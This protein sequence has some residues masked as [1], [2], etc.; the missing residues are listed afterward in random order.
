LNLDQEG[1]SASRNQMNGDP[2]PMI[3]RDDVTAET[4]CPLPATDEALSGLKEAFR[5]HAPHLELES[6]DTETGEPFVVVT[7]P[8]V[9]ADAAAC[10]TRNER[11]WQMHRGGEGPLYEFTTAQEV[12]EFVGSGGLPM[13]LPRPATPPVV[14]C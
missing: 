13:A 4:Y 5:I 9:A 3:I 7:V 11:G 14:P 2:F 1:L 8:G 12:A 10:I 6:G